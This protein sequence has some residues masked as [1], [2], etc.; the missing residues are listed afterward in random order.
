MSWNAAALS[1]GV[2][3]IL[4]GIPLAAATSSL[5]PAVAGSV[6]SHVAPFFATHGAAARMSAI[7]SN[8]WAGYAV[9]GAKGAVTDVKG[10]WT[11]PSVACSGSSTQYGAFWV[12]IDGFTSKTVEQ[13]GTDSDCAAGTP[14]YYAWFEF[15]PSPSHLVS[16]VPIHAGDVISAEVSYSSTT[17][18]FTLTLK[19]LTTGKSF[20]KASAV[21]RAQRTSAE[22]IA[23]APSSTSGVLPLA[24]FGLVHFGYDNTSVNTTCQATV[25]TMTGDLAAFS[26]T[27]I[28]MTGVTNPSLVKATASGISLDG[29]SFYVTWKAAGP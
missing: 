11:Q 5:P 14:S 13:T 6:G 21:K 27:S 3:A 8:N 12:G 15:Y 29:T 4:L 17:A 28:T 7:T 26:V 16:T 18:K 23:E 22:W 19:D 9:S 1:V 24:N 25:G 2:V 10:S 20:S